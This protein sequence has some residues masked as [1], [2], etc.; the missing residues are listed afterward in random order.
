M[1]NIF[2]LQGRAQ[3]VHLGKDDNGQ[4]YMA[5][6]FN[7]YWKEGK[8]KVKHSFLCRMYGGHIG[9]LA[10]RIKE[11]QHLL[12]HGILVASSTNDGMLRL[13]RIEFLEGGAE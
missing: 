6:L 13:S 4:G 12:C 1:V 7:H 8:E 9:A 5:F 11:N 3:N 10:P 2:I